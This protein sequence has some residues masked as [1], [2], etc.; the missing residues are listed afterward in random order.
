MSVRAI[1]CLNG[2]AVGNESDMRMVLIAVD[3]SDAS[4]SAAERAHQL[5]GGDAIPVLVAK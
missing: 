1:P 2:P 3:D 5:F 4:T